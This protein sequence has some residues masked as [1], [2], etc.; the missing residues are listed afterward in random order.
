MRPNDK[1][2]IVLESENECSL[3][4]NT[5]TTAMM[6]LEPAVV[7]PG[8][9]R[10]IGELAAKVSDHGGNDPSKEL[11][12]KESERSVLVDAVRVAT[13]NYYFARGVITRLCEETGL[14]VEDALVVASRSESPLLRLSQIAV[15]TGS[16]AMKLST[17]LTLYG[18][19]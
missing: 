6:E 4:L 12:L 10:Q 2:G 3:A 14:T 15:A 1:G 13:A 19:K 5:L 11:E 18:G 16:A 17:L 9:S 8:T 7:G